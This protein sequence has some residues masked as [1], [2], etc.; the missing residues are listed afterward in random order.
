MNVTK[1]GIYVKIIINYYFCIKFQ[2]FSVN[3][4]VTEGPPTSTHPVNKILRARITPMR[5][6]WANDQDVAHLQTKTVPKNFIWSESVQ[7]L[8]SSSVRK[9]PGGRLN[10]KDGLTRYGDSHVKDKTS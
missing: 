3:K 6:Q 7:W 5:P 1:P 10:K 8:R 2:S 4:Q 9:I